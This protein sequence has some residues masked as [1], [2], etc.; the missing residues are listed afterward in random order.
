MRQISPRSLAD[1]LADA[2]RDQPQLLDV[3][4]PWEFE[5]CHIAG[6][7]H[8][9]MHTVPARVG[10]LDPGCDVVVVCH[11]GGRSMQ[12]AM[13]LERNGFGSV[14]NLMGGVEAW[15]QEVDPAMRRY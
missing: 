14:H 15:A 11:H 1:W 2:G 6:S 5:L 4:E 7:R 12:V 9:P 10:E 3:R 8:L 13:F